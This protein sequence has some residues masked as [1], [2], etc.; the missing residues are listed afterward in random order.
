MGYHNYA[1]RAKIF[2]PFDALKGLSEALREQERIV[3]R[4]ERKD[5][6]PDQTELIDR[7]LH[8]VSEGDLIEI[9]YYDGDAYVKKTGLIS[10][11]F[12]E[13]KEIRVVD[14][15]ISFFDI[16]GIKRV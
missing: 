11:I 1:D 6:L 13:K 7:Q 10:G 3:V 14:Q 9:I 5:L 15:R 4:M 16:Y 12:P 8:T 2:A